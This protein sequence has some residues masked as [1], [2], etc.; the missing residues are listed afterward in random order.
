[1]KIRVLFLAAMVVF[2][3][4]PVLAQQQTGTLLGRVTDTSGAALPGVTV[5]LT[6]PTILGGASTAITNAV[7]GYRIPNV[8]AGTYKLTFELAGF[9][10]TVFE[11]V[12]AQVG[13]SFTI[14]AQLAVGTI[15]ESVTVSGVAPIIETGATDVSFTFTKELM[16]TIPNARDV[17][18]MVAQAPGMTMAVNNV[19]GTN[20]GNQANFR[21][22]GSDP[23]QNVFLLNGVNVTDNT[24]VGGSQLYYDVDSFEEVQIEMNSHSAEVQSPGIVL[25]M[26]PKAGTNNLRGTGT[27]YYG[28]DAIQSDNVDD[29]LRA[30]GVDRA[31]NLHEYLD[32]GFDLGGPI[33]RDRVWFWGAFRWQEIER[34]VTG[35]RN[36]DG[37]FPIDRTFLWY[38]S[39][40]I[41]WLATQAHRVSGFLNFQQK[42][43]F[44]SG[45][46]ALR[47]LDTTLDQM[48]NPVSRVV[49]LRDD[50]TV[51]SR[52]FLSVRANYLEGAFQTRA[53]P[54]ID[55]NTTPARLEL[56]TNVWSAAPPST[57]TSGRKVVSAGG[58]LNHS[59][60][61]WGGQHDL[62]FGSEFSWMEAPQESGYPADHRLRFLNGQ[63]LE[64][65]LFGPGRQNSVVV[66][67]SAFAQDGWQAGRFTLNLGLRWD[68]QSAYL[69][70]EIAP[71]SRFLSEPVRQT[72]TDNLIE[73]STVAPR[74]GII[75]D[76]AGNSKTLL[77]GSLSR[78]YWTLWTGKASQASVAGDRTFRH[79]W[80][81]VNGDAN[82][83]S[84][85]LG[86]VL[87]VD[88]PATRPITID[89][90]LEPSLTD[91]VTAGIAHELMANLSL[92][93]TYM[94]RKDKNL[95]WRI[96]R[97][98]SPADYTAVTG[99]DP[100]PDGTRG[101]SDDGGELVFYE[102]SA[103]KRTL[104][105]DFITTRPGYSQDYRGVELTAHRRMS[106]R[107]QLV[108]S[109]TIGSQRE[110]Y[111][112]GSFQNP[113]DID[114]LDGTRI[115][116]SRPYVGKI[117]GSYVL[118]HD[119]MVSG[120]YQY[121]SG[122]PFTRTVNSVNAL[123]RNLN[124]GNVAVLA[125]ERNA[126][127]L[128]SQHLLDLR[129][130]YDLPVRRA[131]ISLALDLFNALNANTVTQITSVSGPAYNRVID[132][133]PPRILR[134]G[135]RVRF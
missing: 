91:E 128:G 129:V 97:D 51:S 7:G 53:R 127:S 110:Q 102:I 92:S 52:S 99:I 43:R 65:L 77:K 38:P 37:S 64:V 132:F 3:A 121:L 30:R 98:I 35:T 4:A 109:L 106:S 32:T 28:G 112:S 54:G 119:I 124:Q 111:G 108:T 1:M 123:G 34:F 58:T 47:P 18:A 68:Y 55:T 50:W 96:H 82:F 15:Q 13:T 79:G 66:S 42:K 12:R 130:G 46:S 88:D 2:G 70:E 21:A 76:I 40:K 26:V 61:G 125:G 14:D 84:N 33:A 93:A 87:S 100:G 73:W 67:R 81:D 11:G 90:D 80:N 134:F 25:N 59:A 113:Q 86:T 9:Q 105:P 85:E 45:L 62:K 135:A 44:N 133:I 74:F 31:S 71:T 114:K 117:M 104:S 89:P 24:G 8:P 95:D 16:E 78:Y 5:T 83:T 120:F 57:I 126:E 27:I 63:P 20:T 122:T 75:Y 107:W 116:T 94:Y 69:P 56:S 131:N 22:H 23:R 115:D 103:A 101:T 49:S 41:D 39:L 29:E 72:K 36:P 17:W 10:T 19:G 118:P 48:N 6:G 60:T